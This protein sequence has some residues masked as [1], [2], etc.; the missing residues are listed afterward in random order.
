MHNARI[1]ISIRILTILIKFTSPSIYH[2]ILTM[3]ISS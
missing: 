3:E 1:Y 2:A